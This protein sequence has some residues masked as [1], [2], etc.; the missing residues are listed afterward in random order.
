M[1][2]LI[3]MSEILNITLPIPVSVNQAYK[4]RAFTS[5]GRTIAGI[6]KTAEAKNYQKYA[7]QTIQR[8][9]KLQNWVSNP[10]DK[11][12]YVCVDAIVHFPR[13]DM[14]VNNLWKLLLDSVRDTQMIVPNDNKVLERAIRVYYDKDNPRVEL[15]IYYAPFVGVFDCEDDYKR[16]KEMNCDRCTRQN[17]N[18][19]IIA[20]ALESRT[21]QEINVVEGSCL[22]LKL[23]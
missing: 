21:Q 8:E 13:T 9:I 15:Q 10:L 22:I 19:S 3:T 2:V 18:C 14:D 12:I 4:P 5:G 20:K 16:F 17:R 11:N 1:E 6:Y 7:T 23:K